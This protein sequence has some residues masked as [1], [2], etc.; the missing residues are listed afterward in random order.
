MYKNSFSKN[1]NLLFGM[2]TAFTLCASAYH[3]LLNL[4]LTDLGYAEGFIGQMA[5][6]IAVGTMISTIPIAWLCGRYPVKW[7]ILISIILSIVSDLIILFNSNGNALKSGALLGGASMGA[8]MIATAP[9]VMRNASKDL[10]GSV[11]SIKHGLASVGA[12]IAA[13]VFA[14]WVDHLISEGSPSNLAFQQ[15]LIVATS[16]KVFVIILGFFI[17]SQ[18][19]LQEERRNLKDFLTTRDWRS[20]GRVIIPIFIIGLGAGQ[21]MPFMNLYFKTRFE[22]STGEI[23]TYF[24]ICQFFIATGSFIGPLFAKKNGNIKVVLITQTLSLPFMV[25]LAFTGSLWW[26]AGAFFIR[27][28]L[29]NMGTPLYHHF[30]L[31]MVEPK[32]QAVT[33]AMIALGWNTGWFISSWIGGIV[34]EKYGFTPTIVSTACFY[35][36]ATLVQ[37]KLFSNQTYKDIG[38]ATV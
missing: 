31:E 16:F 27:A 12:G 34:I 33:N 32:E 17:T 2:I 4:Y 30:S 5:G 10:R 20:L 26:A 22:L 14:K 35:A 11:F 19:P 24:F 6:L 18:P 23:G 15:V 29:M 37:I 9:F 21:T 13:V 8:W 28:T 25:I 3:V 1:I 36:I 7:I 38:K